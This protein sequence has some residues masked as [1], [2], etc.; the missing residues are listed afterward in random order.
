M[1]YGFFTRF[2]SLFFLHI[3]TLHPPPTL[4]LPFPCFFPYPGEELR[5]LAW[6]LNEPKFHKRNCLLKFEIFHCELMTT[7]R[8]KTITQ[9]KREKKGRGIVL[10]FSQ[11]K[12]VL[13]LIYLNNKFSELLFQTQ[14]H[15]VNINEFLVEWLKKNQCY[16]KKTVN[17]KS[18]KQISYFYSHFIL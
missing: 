9:T 18:Y 8:R 11:V 17:H 2:L 14:H 1:S 12:Y 3:S 16:K 4:H 5:S 6:Q 13:S 7:R 15:K 10:L